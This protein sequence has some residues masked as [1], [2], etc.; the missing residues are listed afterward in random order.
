MAIRRR[1]VLGL[2]AAA[3]VAVMAGWPAA[4][5]VHRFETVALGTRV[6]VWLYGL[7]E[8]A[9]AAL[10]RELFDELLRLEAIF[11]LHREDAPLVRLARTG[12]LREPPPELLELLALCRRLHHASAGAFDPTV[13]PLYAA[14]AGLARARALADPRRVAATLDVLGGLLGFTRVVVE[15]RCI[16]LPPGAALTLNGIAQGYIADRLAARL[17]AAGLGFAL[18]D[19]GE[20]RALGPPREQ[21]P[22][23]VALRAGGRWRLRA[24][25]LA[26]SAPAATRFD[27]AGRYHHILDPLSLRPARGIRRAVVA[28]ES[29]ALADGL[30]T[31][32]CVLD[33]DAGLDLARRFDARAQ[34]LT[35]DRRRYHTGARR[36]V[37]AAAITSAATSGRVPTGPV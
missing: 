5:A 1:R 35:T 6:Q 8:A 7:E 10:A 31:A 30:A 21:A 17:E 3:P 26:V 11:T 18:I 29:A 20:L 23:E 14:L 27:P 37:P 25:A 32:L 34:I 2:L 33:P 15:P 4:P 24:G 9:A 19:S 28:A 36:M 22:F 12:E 13:Q 16:R